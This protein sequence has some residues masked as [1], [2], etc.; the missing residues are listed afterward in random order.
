MKKYEY[1]QVDEGDFWEIVEILDW[2]NRKDY[3]GLRKLFMQKVSP[4]ASVEFADIYR[5]KSKELGRV[6]DEYDKQMES[7]GQEGFGLGGDSFG[8]NLSHIIG[9]GKREYEKN[10]KEPELGLKRAHDLDFVESFSYCVPIHDSD[11]RSDYE[12]LNKEYYQLRAKEYL[13]QMEEGLDM[14]EIPNKYHSSIETLKNFLEKITEGSF[15]EVMDNSEEFSVA[16]KK[17]ERFLHYGIPNLVH[18]MSR[19]Y[20]N[21]PKKLY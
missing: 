8:D 21:D 6:F 10:L 15:E 20:F 11:T 18:D 9:L 19:Y 1:T 5:Q 13:G 16:F 17:C 7:V 14:S 4:E 12:L 2:E 3:D